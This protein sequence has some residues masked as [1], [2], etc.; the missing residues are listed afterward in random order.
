MIVKGPALAA[1]DLPKPAGA[2]PPS[3]PFVMNWTGFYVGAQ[4]GYGYGAQRRLDHLCDAR[5]S[6]RPKQSR[7][8]RDHFRRRQQHQ[9]RR[10]RRD[11]RRACRL[12]PAVRQMGRRRRGLGRSHA[13]EPEPFD[14]RSQ[15]GGG[16]RPARSALAP[17]RPARSGR[18]IQGSVRARAGYALRPHAVLWDGAASP[19]AQFGSNFQVYGNDLT[20]APFYAADQRSSTRA[21]WTLGGGVEYAV[22]PHWSVRGEYR[23]T[24]F[25]HMGDF[26]AATSTGRGLRRRSPS[27]PEPGAGRLELPVQAARRRPSRPRR[28]PPIF[29]RS[30]GRR[31]TP[32]RPPPGRAFTPA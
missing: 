25:G 24:D 30:R 12:Q 9:R 14:Q 21:G 13:H 31:S 2:P 4:I 1:N 29:R 16:S 6:R 18:T 17:R 26:P 27:R 5:R 20:L 32:R 15:L 7:Q 11:R 3:L 10:D 28:A 19:L 22:N 8:Q 23:Y